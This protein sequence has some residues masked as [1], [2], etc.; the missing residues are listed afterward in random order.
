MEFFRN[1]KDKIKIGVIVFYNKK[2]NARFFTNESEALKFSYDGFSKGG[3][4]Y[5]EHVFSDTVENKYVAAM[6]E[7]KGYEKTMCL[8][9]RRFFDQSLIVLEMIKVPCWDEKKKKFVLKYV[10]RLKNGLCCCSLVIW[11]FENGM[12]IK[13]PSEKIDVFFQ[14]DGILEFNYGGGLIS[15]RLNDFSI[16]WTKKNTK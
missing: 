1:L 12:K 4:H 8:P 3:D 7:K 9:S 11:E 13:N 14:R 2:N 6:M 16:Q 15:A 5:P 10:E